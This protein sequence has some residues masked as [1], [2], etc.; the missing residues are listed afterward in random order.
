MICGVCGGS[1]INR[2]SGFACD[3]CEGTGWIDWMDVLTPWVIA[4]LVT[5]AT[6]T[7]GRW[8]WH[9]FAK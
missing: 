3:H 4:I 5:G 6:L 2:H 8:L 9:L 1:G 7:V